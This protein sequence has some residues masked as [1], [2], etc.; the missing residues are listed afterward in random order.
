MD[1]SKTPLTPFPRVDF[2]FCFHISIANR[3]TFNPSTI[4]TWFLFYNTL[5]FK[6]KIGVAYTQPW[7]EMG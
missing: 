7:Q 4:A 2:Y 6:T 1:F 3:P 5:T